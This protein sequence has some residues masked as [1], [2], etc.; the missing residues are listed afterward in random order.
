LN[1][2]KSFNYSEIAATGEIAVFVTLFLAGTKGISWCTKESSLRNVKRNHL[3]QSTLGALRLFGQLMAVGY[4]LGAN[5][6]QIKV[7]P[8]KNNQLCCFHTELDGQY[9]F[10]GQLIPYCGSGRGKGSRIT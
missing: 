6:A 4:L 8:M 5:Q 7:S 3:H 9:T 1:Y 2:F 10:N